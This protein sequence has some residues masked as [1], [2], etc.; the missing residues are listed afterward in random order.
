MRIVYTIGYTS[1]EINKFIEVL[2]KYKV[3]CL[4][5]VRS[6]PKSSYYKDYDDANLKLSLKKEGIIY[7]NYKEEFGARQNDEQYYS[8]GYLDFDKFSKS[9][10]FNL[11]IEKIKNAQDLGYG[12]CIMCAEKDPINCHRTILIARNLYKK[13]FEINHILSSEETCSQ[14]DIDKRLLDEFFPKRNQISIFDEDNLNEEELI[15]RAYKLKNEKI[16]FVLEDE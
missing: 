11:G 8:K 2:K 12:V 1:F 6:V 7:R 15:E 9:E 3:S 4:I 14:T 10:Q 16:G 13:G 5:D